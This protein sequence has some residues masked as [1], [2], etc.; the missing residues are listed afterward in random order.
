M[1]N[2]VGLAGSSFNQRTSADAHLCSDLSCKTENESKNKPKKKNIPVNAFFLGKTIDISFNGS[3]RWN[4]ISDPVLFLF[5]PTLLRF[6][7]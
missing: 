6:V 4:S 5:Y 1:D 7:D 2:K 3:T